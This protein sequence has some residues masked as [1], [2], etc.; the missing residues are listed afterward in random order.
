MLTVLPAKQMRL[1]TLS[2]ALADESVYGAES[3]KHVVL[4]PGQSQV[5]GCAYC[6]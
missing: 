6:Q 1:Q 2:D 5:S 3:D 4:R